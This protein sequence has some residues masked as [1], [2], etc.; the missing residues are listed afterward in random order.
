M[1]LAHD[2][3][4]KQELPEADGIPTLNELSAQPRLGLAAAFILR[5]HFQAEI[6]WGGYSIFT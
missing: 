5:R 1:I 4:V 3:E 2:S 6:R